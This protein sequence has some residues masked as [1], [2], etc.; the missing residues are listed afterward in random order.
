MSGLL[1]AEDIFIEKLLVMFV[2]HFFIYHK[3]LLKVLLT[4]IYK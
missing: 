1:D 3:R 2:A 4:T